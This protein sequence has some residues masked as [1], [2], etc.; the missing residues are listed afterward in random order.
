M[1]QHPIKALIFTR[2]TPL[3]QGRAGTWWPVY[4]SIFGKLRRL[5]LAWYRIA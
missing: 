2:G 1:K 3:E 5:P 4:V